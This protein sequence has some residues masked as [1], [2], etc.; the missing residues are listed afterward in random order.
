M[1]IRVLVT[2][3]GLAIL[4][5]GCTLPSLEQGWVKPAFDEQ[6]SK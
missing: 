1:A 4:V 5:G 6:T 2:A 3:V